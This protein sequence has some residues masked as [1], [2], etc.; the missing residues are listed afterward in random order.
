MFRSGL[1]SEISC[2]GWR[3]TTDEFQLTYPRTQ[4]TLPANANDRNATT[5]LFSLRIYATMTMVETFRWLDILSY[6]NHYYK[7]IAKEYHVID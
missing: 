3:K 6:A 4:Q 5:T 2:L 1:W 7:G